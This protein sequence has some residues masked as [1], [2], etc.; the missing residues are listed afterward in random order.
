M[1]RV[2]IAMLLIGSCIVD[3]QAQPAPRSEPTPQPAGA[4]QPADEDL[5]CDGLRTQLAAAEGG[6]TPQL[7]SED[8]QRRERRRR[9]FGMAMRLVGSLAPA[10]GPRSL[11]A[12]QAVAAAQAIGSTVAAGQAQHDTQTAVDAQQPA[13]AAQAHAARLRALAH[14]KRC[15]WADEPAQR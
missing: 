14:E 11:G 4:A 15:D 3:A 12:A 10:I 13:Q 8:Q 5:T 7:V 1:R 6:A 2:A 9:G